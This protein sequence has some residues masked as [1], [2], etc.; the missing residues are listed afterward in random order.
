MYRQ[1][2]T[3]YLNTHIITENEVGD[4]SDHNVIPKIHHRVFLLL[5]TDVKNKLPTRL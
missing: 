2:A 4:T 1:D 3:K 5:F